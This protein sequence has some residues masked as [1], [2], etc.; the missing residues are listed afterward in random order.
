MQQIME[1]QK[2]V[3]ENR[4]MMVDGMD[5]TPLVSNLYKSDPAVISHFIHMIE[6]YNFAIKRPLRQS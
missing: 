6:V 2:V 4:S 5:L 3:N 1:R